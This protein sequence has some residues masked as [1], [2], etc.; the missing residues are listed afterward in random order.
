MCGLTDEQP[1][2]S[3]GKIVVTEQAVAIGVT[4][5]PNPSGIDGDPGADWY[6]WQGMQTDWRLVGTTG[7]TVIGQQYTIDSKAMRKVGPN[8]DVITVVDMQA[9]AGAK[10]STNGRQLIQLH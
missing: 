9:G 1:L 8:Q 10:L 7:V 6:V 3:F 2:G 5:V 4:A